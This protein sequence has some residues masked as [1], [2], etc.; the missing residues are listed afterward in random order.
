VLYFESNEL[1]R[2]EEFL[3]AHYAPMRIGSATAE[4]HA[5]VARADADGVS[6]DRLD[7]G[8]EM[9]YDVTPLGKVCVCDVW[10]G[11]LEDHTPEGSEPATYGR[12]DLFVLSPPDRPYRGTIN[13]ARYGLT[14][15]DPQLLEQVAGPTSSGA[16]VELLDHR[17]VSAAAAARLRAAIEHLD[18]HVL[19]DPAVHEHPLV[20]ATAVQYV[21]AQVL[22]TF[23]NTAGAESRSATSRDAHPATVRRAVDFIEAHAGTAISLADIAAAAHVSVRALQLAFRRHLDTTPTA[24][25]RAVRLAGVRRDLVDADPNGATV[26]R[27]AARWGFAH[28]G[29]F[30]ITYRDAFG[31]TPGSTLRGDRGD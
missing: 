12:G 29:R 1:D 3:S 11:T 21:A 15:L 10:S 9:S 7:L 5:K 8:F 2:T 30:G 19:S 22:A 24:F 28:Q 23:A 16:P 31:E 4:S 14:M 27:I 18:R 25:L 6:I 20:V 26:A 13:H 17:P